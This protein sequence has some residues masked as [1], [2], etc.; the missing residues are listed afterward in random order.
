MDN[1]IK[2]LNEMGLTKNESI[3]YITLL[4]LKT[5]KTGEILKTANLNTGKIYE[6]LESLKKKGLINESI[7][8]GIKYF[9]ASRPEQLLEFNKKK[10][11]K[12]EKEEKKIQIILPN[13]KKM[14]TSNKETKFKSVTYI[15]YKGIK[16][17]IYEA[18]YELEKGEEIIAMAVT[19][20]KDEKYNRMW[21][22]FHKLRIEKKIKFRLIFSERG[23]YFNKYKKFKLCEC[24]IL[25][26]LTPV[27][28]NVFGNNIVGIFN[29]QDPVS[30]VL[31]YNKNV[32]TSFKH[33]FDQL[34]KIA[35][36]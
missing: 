29:Y 6:I 16:T 19:E 8:D 21:T 3:I 11:E 5:A 31:I 14:Y 13:L 17:A 30:C 32:T 2:I 22:K 26:G 24:K 34:W 7:I 12:L 4:K 18:L 1:T 33:F 27:A 9:G 15:G 25:E 10:K 28:V 20:K 23:K 36:P 35:K